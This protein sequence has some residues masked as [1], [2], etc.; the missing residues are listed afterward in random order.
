MLVAMENHLNQVIQNEMVMVM[1]CCIGPGSITSQVLD[2]TGCRILQ[3]LCIEIHGIVIR[4]QQV[5]TELL[6]G[7][8]ARRYTFQG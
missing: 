4:L 2:F 7:L 6:F 3:V 5:F 1:A 8:Q